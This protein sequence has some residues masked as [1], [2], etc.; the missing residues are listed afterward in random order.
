MEISSNEISVNGEEIIYICLQL[1]LW[2]KFPKNKPKLWKFTRISTIN[3]YLMFFKWS[4]ITLFWGNFEPPKIC[5]RKDF[6]FSHVCIQEAFRRCPRG[7]W[8]GYR[9]SMK[10]SRGF[11]PRQILWKF[12]VPRIFLNQKFLRPKYFQTAYYFKLKILEQK[13]FKKQIY[14]DQNFYGYQFFRAQI[15]QTHN[16]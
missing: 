9:I 15:F 4:Q 11:W 8:R 2:S 14:S 12:L 3:R 1:Y 5:L 13:F 16:F 6:N 10:A 7:V